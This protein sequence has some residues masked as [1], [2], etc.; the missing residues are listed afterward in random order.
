M[1]GALRQEI[2]WINEESIKHNYGFKQGFVV[3]GEVEV[4][5]KIQDNNIQ[6][7]PWDSLK[8]EPKSNLSWLLWYNSNL[9][10]K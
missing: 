7:K 8:I 6:P 3:V 2:F 5:K 4:A 9:N 1:K 10:T